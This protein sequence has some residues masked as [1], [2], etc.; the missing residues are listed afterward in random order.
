MIDRRT[1]LMAG[2]AFGALVRSGMRL[3]GFPVLLCWT[4]PFADLDRYIAVLDRMS[5]PQ[6]LEV[7]RR[8]KA[9]YFDGVNDPVRERAFLER[10]GRIGRARP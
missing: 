10:I 3:D 1:L 8:F 2:A 7:Y 9:F 5:D 4:R 6:A